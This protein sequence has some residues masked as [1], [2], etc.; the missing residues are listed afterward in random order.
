MKKMSIPEQKL[1]RLLLLL[2]TELQDF[3]KRAKSGKVFI[4]ATRFAY[5]GDNLKVSRK[6]TARI[7]SD[8]LH[9]L[10]EHGLVKLFGKT[11][12]CKLYLLERTSMLWM[13]I[14]SANIVCIVDTYIEYRRG[15]IRDLKTSLA[16]CGE[17]I[18]P[19]KTT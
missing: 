9:D 15:K 2:F 18:F 13:L 5:V 3:L 1:R 10:E 17:S 16:R 19:E 8:L 14:E 7:V 6:L 11:S 12:R 4:S